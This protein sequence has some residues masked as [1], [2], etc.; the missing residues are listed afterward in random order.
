MRASPERDVEH[1]GAA[2]DA[3]Q[4]QAPLERPAGELEL[5]GV[6][7][8]LGRRAAGGALAVVHRLDVAAGGEHDRVEL[9]ERGVDPLGELGERDRE[10]ARLQQR[11]LHAHPAVVAEVVQARR[12]ADQWARARHAQ[13]GPISRTCQKCSWQPGARPERLSL[14]DVWRRGLR[15]RVPCLR[16]FASR[17]ARLGRRGDWPFSAEGS[18]A[19]YRHLLSWRREW[20]S[21]DQTPASDRT[22]RST[23]RASV[24]A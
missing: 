16:S 3:E 6:T 21:R 17:T 22:R 1:L 10:P 15:P 20:A 13:H 11:A 5:E 4:R 2:A 24:V 9:L 14:D 23:S 7:A 8:R 18:L 19:P 12:D